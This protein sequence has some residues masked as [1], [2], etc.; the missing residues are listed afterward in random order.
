MR[1]KISRIVKSG[2]WEGKFKFRFCYE[3]TG[4]STISTYIMPTGQKKLIL[5]IFIPLRR[6]KKRLE[7]NV[8]DCFVNRRTLHAQRWTVIISESM[9]YGWLY[10]LYF[11]YL[12]FLIFFIIN[13]CGFKNFLNES[14]NHLKNKCT[15]K[16]GEIGNSKA[17]KY[18][19]LKLVYNSW[20]LKP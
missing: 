17:S 20:A 14:K 11:P 4:V 10:F 18:L 19:I 6:R 13:T 1:R 3:M 7:N 5:W 8:Y 9:D 2:I 16:F 15:K 12:Y